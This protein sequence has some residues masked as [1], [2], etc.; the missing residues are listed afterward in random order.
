MITSSLNPEV[1]KSV[2]S[3]LDRFHPDRPLEVNFYRPA[4]YKPGNP[5]VIVQH[6]ML[7]NGDEY[8]D[9]W[10]AAA[11]KHG[12]LIAAPTFSDAAFPMAES[13]NNGLVL[14][15]VGRVRDQQ[16]WLYGVL[17]GCLLH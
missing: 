7:R 4:H 5:V 17:L 2:L 3:F 13:Y 10:I 15:S 1:G 8:R 11:E 16:E 14:D 6:G 12:L 9:F